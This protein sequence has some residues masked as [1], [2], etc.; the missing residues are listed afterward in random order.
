MAND[1]QAT[2]REIIQENQYMTVATTD[3][4]R[5][6]LAPV[7]FC[8]DEELN[9]YFVS[10]PTSRHAEHIDQNPRV[11]V[12]IFDSQQP[13]FT[14][15]GLQAEGTASKYSEDENPFATIGGLDMPTNLQELVPGYLAYKVEPAHF[16]VPR[17]HLEG[18]LRDERLEVRMS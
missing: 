1:H 9:F 18:A 6:W 13:P 7:Q 16:Y 14:G 3:G 4:E 2:V 12:A 17:G 11:G 8:A 15:R 5:P 10:L